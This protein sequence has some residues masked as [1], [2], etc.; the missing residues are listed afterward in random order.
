MNGCAP[1]VFFGK[2][3]WDEE[4]ESENIRKHDLDFYT[5]VLVFLDPNRKI[6][7]DEKHSLTEER[8]FCVGSIGNQ[9][10]TVRFTQRKNR[11]RMIGAG[12]WRAGRK[13]YEA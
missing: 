1:T 9:V 6:A 3:E 2:F 5:A 4:K 8:L 11:I 13:L 10:A 12:F 7:I